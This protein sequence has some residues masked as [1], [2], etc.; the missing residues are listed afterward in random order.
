[1]PCN[2]GDPYFATKMKKSIGLAVFLFIGACCYAQTVKINICVIQNGVLQNVHA[3]YNTSTRDTTIAINGQ[4][5][6][7]REVYSR[8]GKRVRRRDVVVR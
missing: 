8:A 2:G 3:D 4:V 6:R 1:M 5:K 7:F